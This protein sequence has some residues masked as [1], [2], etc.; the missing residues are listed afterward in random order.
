VG[1]ALKSVGLAFKPGNLNVSGSIE[2]GGTGYIKGDSDALDDFR[3]YQMRQWR[4]LGK[5]RLEP[6]DV[7]T[8]DL[9]I[10]TSAALEGS[11]DK[12]MVN[13]LRER[14]VAATLWH[15]VIPSSQLAN[16]ELENIEDIFVYIYSNAYQRQ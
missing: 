11:E 8:V 13:N 16:I 5:G 15:L 10:P 9:S 2:Y 3:A 1:V 4:D 7:R 14:P 6:V 12:Y